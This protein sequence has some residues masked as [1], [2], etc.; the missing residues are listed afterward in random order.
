[1]STASSPYIYDGGVEIVD[2]GQFVWRIGKALEDLF[3][4]FSKMG[5]EANPVR[6]ADAG[7]LHEA[8]YIGDFNPHDVFSK[9]AKY[10]QQREFRIAVTM[11]SD[12][13]KHNYLHLNIGSISDIA[14]SINM[15]NTKS[16]GV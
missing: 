12:Q 2:I 6:Y 11:K 9:R 14:R 15:S 1:M 5:F 3:P 13:Q 4:D 7:N 10:A 8:R 16:L